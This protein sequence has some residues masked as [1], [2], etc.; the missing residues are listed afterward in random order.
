MP[1]EEGITPQ[2]LGAPNVRG[3]RELENTIIGQANLT[4][5]PFTN[6]NLFVS[7]S[8]IRANKP[9]YA[10]D[11]AG[12]K[13]NL[14]AKDLGWEI[15]F[16]ADYKMHDGKV[17]LTLRGGYFKPGKAAGYLINGTD[18]Y[19]KAAWELKGEVWFNF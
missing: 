16:K 10:W 2:G 9:I 4:F 6:L 3:Y 14:S 5:I 11:A 1:D 17:I 19:K 13:P 18:E 12:P 15:D 7:Y 8:Y